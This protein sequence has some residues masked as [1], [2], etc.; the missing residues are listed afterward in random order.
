MQHEPQF[1]ALNLGLGQGLDKLNQHQEPL[2]T[3]QRLKEQSKPV[4]A[5]KSDMFQPFRQQPS[6]SLLKVVQQ[7]VADMKELY[8]WD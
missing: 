1:G 5:D 7:L 2:S 8:L 6:P 4:F 3:T